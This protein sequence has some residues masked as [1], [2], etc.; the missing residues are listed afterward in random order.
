MVGF[1]AHAYTICT[2]N[3][4]DCAYPVHQL[5]IS[6]LPALV[7]SLLPKILTHIS[8]ETKINIFVLFKGDLCNDAI[9][10]EC[11]GP[12]A[13]CQMSRELDVLGR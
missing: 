13:V 6:F 9:V 4:S 7:R 11:C 10:A 2:Q 1:W 3:N 8:I 5:S 12:C